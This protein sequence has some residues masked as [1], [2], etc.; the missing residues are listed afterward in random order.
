MNFW[1]RGIFLLVILFLIVSPIAQGGIEPKKTSPLTQKEK[2]SLRYHLENLY[3]ELDL[4]IKNRRADLADLLRQ[5]Q[6]ISMLKV[7]E[8]IPLER[9]L[10]GLQQ[11]LKQSAKNLSI[12]H[13]KVVR[14]SPS[15]AP[16][17]KA[18]YTS[19]RAFHFSQAQLVE[20]I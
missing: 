3:N 9:D 7:Y 4:L 2:H 10:D 14:Y 19:D 16:P 1:G 17:P 6:E 20:Q 12:S 11:L 5:E 8:R 18:V 13:F 15:P